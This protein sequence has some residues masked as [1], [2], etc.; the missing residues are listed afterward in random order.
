[1]DL[2]QSRP[3]LEHE[4]PAL[5][6]PPAKGKR[7]AGLGA[8]GLAAVIG[9]TALFALG[10]LPRMER[11]KQLAAAAETSSAARPTVTVIQARRSSASSDLL[12]PGNIQAIDETSIFARADGYLRRRMVDIGD[13][14]TARQPLAEIETPELD[15]Q[16]RQA[17]ASVEQSRAALE[18]TRAALKQAEA[19]VLQAQANLELAEVTAKRWNSLVREGVLSQQ[20]GDEK[21]SALE[22]R[23]ADLE[24]AHASVSASQAN[25]KAALASVQASEA[26][27]QRLTELQSFQNVVAPFAGVITARNIDVGALI[28]SGSGAN[29]RPMFNIA[30]IDRL[31]IYVNMPQTFV[32]SLHVGQTAD[33]L[34]QEFPGR[35]FSG[36]VTRT[37]NTLDQSAH[38]LLTEVQVANPDRSLLPGMYAQ[39]KF[40]LGRTS[41]PVIVPAEALLVRSEGTFI[42]TVGPKGA[43][44]YQRVELGRDYG[45]QIELTSG[46][47]SGELVALNPTDDLREGESVETV[48]REK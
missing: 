45:T 31:R 13:Q 24:A 15:Q 9:L 23:K 29:M 35:K 43:L 34:L 42:L 27:L 25:L 33:V 40:M 37:S 19:G 46:L 18:Q 20:D 7:T 21:R 48:Q 44:H 17:S 3:V 41:P 39:V 10:Y 36:S 47:N 16:I 6:A 28:T 2:K 26:N 5:T 4:E 12:L 11:Q 8:L 22:A 32:P 38:T 14:V 30:Q 1:M